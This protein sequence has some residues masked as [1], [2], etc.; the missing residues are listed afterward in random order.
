M[1]IFALSLPLMITH[2]LIFLVVYLHL[3]LVWMILPS[4]QK[5]SVRSYV[6]LKSILRRTLMDCLLF[7]T[8]ELRSLSFTL[9]QFF[10]RSIIDLHTLPAEWKNAIITPIFKKGCSSDPANYRP[11]A[12]TCTC[13]KILECIVANEIICFLNSHK[14]ITK[15][16]HGFLQKH[17][18]V[19]NLLESVNDWTF[20]ISNRKSVVI[21]YIDFKR[22]FDSVSH[23]KLIHKLASYGI[24][25]NLL[26][27]ISSFLSNRMQYVRVG[28]S[29]SK[30]SRV[31][32]GVPQGSVIGP[33][34][35]NL[36]INDITD[37]LDPSTSSKIFAD[38][39]KLYT[40]FLY[41][42]FT[43]SPSNPPRSH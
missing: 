21:A 17:S 26:F 12:L 32:S 6:N 7:S 23:S 37:N 29:L 27:W 35:F 11:I 39:I 31:T 42:N 15:Q 43:P 36:F 3:P 10:Y 1:N 2:A 28:S 33:L 22:A 30:L 24:H 16:Q 38:D 14:L 5:Q 20:S 34:L 8:T 4:P 25:G 9:F 18:T 13:C 19:T 41:N 40:E